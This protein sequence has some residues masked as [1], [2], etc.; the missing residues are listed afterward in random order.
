MYRVDGLIDY[1]FQR[2]QTGM[3]LRDIQESL[4]SQQHIEDQDRSTI[5]QEVIRREEIKRKG[6]VRKKLLMISGLVGAA[7]IAVLLFLLIK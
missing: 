1:Y 5:I 6:E 3:E 2:K 4:E 7:M